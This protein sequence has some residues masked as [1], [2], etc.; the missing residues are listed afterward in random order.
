[1]QEAMNMFRAA[2]AGALVFTSAV[3]ASAQTAPQNP[4]D[5]SRLPQL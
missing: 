4:G 3:I 5:S 1:M 2:V